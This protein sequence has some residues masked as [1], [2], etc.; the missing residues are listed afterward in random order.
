[1]VFDD[2]PEELQIKELVSGD[3]PSWNKVFSGMVSYL[4]IPDG[5]FRAAF[6]TYHSFGHLVHRSSTF[7]SHRK[8]ACIVSPVVGLQSYNAQSYPLRAADWTNQTLPSKLKNLCN[9]CC[10]S[11]LANI[12]YMLISLLILPLMIN[13]RKHPPHPF[14]W[15]RTLP[16]PLLRGKRKRAFFSSYSPLDYHGSSVYAVAI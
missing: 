14:F 7:D 11:F 3:G 9:G 8:D 16:F 4:W 5:E 1:M 13:P 12:H 6:L 2:D 15:S 10:P